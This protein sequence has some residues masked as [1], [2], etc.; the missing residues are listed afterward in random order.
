MKPHRGE[1]NQ[2]P[3]AFESSSR[4]ARGE[5]RTSAFGLGDTPSSH[6]NLPDPGA[7]DCGL[8]GGATS[9]STCSAD[10]Q[11]LGT[12]QRGTDPAPQV[13]K[14]RNYPHDGRPVKQILCRC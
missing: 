10:R 13:G 7:S 2:E 6:T 12:G 9:P 11:G 8:R 5:L 3:S 1:F 14:I 4:F